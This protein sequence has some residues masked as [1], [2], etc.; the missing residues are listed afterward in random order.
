MFKEEVGGTITPIVQNGYLFLL[1]KEENAARE[2]VS[3]QHKAGLLDA[4]FLS[5]KETVKRFPFVDTDAITGA[6]WCQSDGFLRPGVIYGEAAQRARIEGVEIRQNAPVNKARLKGGR[7]SEVRAGTEWVG[8]DLFIDC[9]NAW[10]PRLA[11]LLG[12]KAVQMAPLKRYLW[13][14]DRGGPMTSETLGNMPMVITPSGAY[15]RPENKESLMVGWAHQTEAEPSF[16][17]EDQ[18]AIENPY[19]HTE[20]DSRAFE[21]WEAIATCLPDV[22]EF[23]GISATT[24]GFYG[25]TPDHNPYLCYDPYRSN[26]IHL[27]GFSGHGAM[28]GPF[29]SYVG[30][31]LAEAGRDIDSIT[32]LGE[33]VSMSAFSMNRKF[34]H[35]ESMVI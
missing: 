24:S 16:E 2:R 20:F 11:A 3:L 30:L 5:A 10:S 19:S 26:L 23:N 27:V 25:T 31:K 32:V 29:S 4:E 7:I 34:Q 13:F 15:C 1:D 21:A 33:D 18:D 6:T 28:F 9:T 14:I 35:S 17:Y 8:G 12:G 22:A